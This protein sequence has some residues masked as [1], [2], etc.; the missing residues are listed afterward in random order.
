MLLLFY[1]SEWFIDFFSIKLPNIRPNVFY[2]GVYV[3][4]THIILSNAF[5]LY[6]STDLLNNIA[7]DSLKLYNI[8]QT[9]KVSNKGRLI[10]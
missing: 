5:F 8:C 10:I 4:I 3:V 7:V 1:W 6:M 2:N 9:M